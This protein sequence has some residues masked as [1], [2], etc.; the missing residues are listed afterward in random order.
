MNRAALRRLVAPAIATVIVCAILIGLGVWQVERLAWKENLIA[1]VTARMTAKPVAAP[2]PIVWPG[3]DV[4]AVEYQPVTVNGRFRNDREVHVIYSLTAPKGPVGGVGYE[5]MTPFVTDEGWT[6]YVNRGFV[7][8]AKRDPATRAEGQIEGETTVTGLIRRPADRSWFMPG[9]NAAKNEWF[10]R[11]P[12]RWA[13]AYG[14]PV[15]SLAPYIVDATFDP[16]LPGG[17]PQGGETIVDFPNS[18][19]G[20]AITWFGLAACCAGVFIAFAIGRLRSAQPPP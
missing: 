13:A 2:G 1:Q 18:H 14:E 8:A 7:P 20:Y 12:L 10:S 19:L 11:D 17:I 16:A 15:M 5:V 9:D 3:L 6:V 4:S